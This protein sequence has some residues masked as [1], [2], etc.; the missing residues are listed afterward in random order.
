MAEAS[1]FI[2]HLGRIERFRVYCPAGRCDEVATAILQ[3][4]V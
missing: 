2:R 1:Q 4:W 3:R